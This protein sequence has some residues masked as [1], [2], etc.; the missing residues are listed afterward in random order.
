MADKEPHSQ[1]PYS[2]AWRSFFQKGMKDTLPDCEK[3]AC[4]TPSGTGD[5]HKDLERAMRS[6][7]QNRVEPS[8]PKHSQISL[9]TLS[10]MIRI[11]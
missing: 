11:F 4:S 2:V 3:R 5:F 9:K 1:C 6:I 10:V 8:Q 7:K